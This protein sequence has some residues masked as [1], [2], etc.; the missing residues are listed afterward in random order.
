MVRYLLSVLPIRVCS[1]YFVLCMSEESKIKSQSHN[2]TVNDR[3]DLRNY[4]GNP[5]APDLFAW[6]LFGQD[7][8]LVQRVRPGLDPSAVA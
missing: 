8:D 1:S 5:L 3:K 7:S 6:A 2:P 4:A